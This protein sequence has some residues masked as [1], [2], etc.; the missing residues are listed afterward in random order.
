[1]GGRPY[2]RACL[3]G[4]DP[5]CLARLH[6]T[7]RPVPSLSDLQRFSTVSSVGPAGFKK[8]MYLT[9]QN[10]A[11]GTLRNYVRTKGVGGSIKGDIVQ[12]IL[13][14]LTYYKGLFFTFFQA[15]TETGISETFNLEIINGFIGKKS[16]SL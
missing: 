12:T 7:P 5:F 6:C 2:Y 1:M 16:L 10:C 4:R 11:W 14:R 15:T 8:L 13:Y 3:G 9:T